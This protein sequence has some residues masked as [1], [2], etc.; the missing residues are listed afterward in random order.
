MDLDQLITGRAAP[1]VRQLAAQ[2]G[3]QLEER[4]L[5]GALDPQR[6]D[7]LRRS[8]EDLAAA[9]LLGVG[10]AT[11]ASDGGDPDPELGDR[12]RAAFAVLTSLASAEGEEAAAAVRQA[13][14]DVVG[15]AMR[16]ALVALTTA[17]RV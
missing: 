11:A 10:T 6:Q 13:V 1:A 12:A 15:T 16:V 2:I 5:A 17:M 9:G 3:R 14:S 7:L 4:V 8:T